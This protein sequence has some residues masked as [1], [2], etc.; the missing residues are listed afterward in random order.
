MP[1]QVFWEDDAQT[2]VRYNFEGTWTWDELYPAYYQAI[3]MEKSVT[4]RVDV[5]LDMRDSG[6]VPANALLHIKNISEKQPPNIGLSIFVTTNAFVTSMYNMAIRVYSKVAYY[7]RITKT[8]EEALAMI[9]A[10]R[11]PVPQKPLSENKTS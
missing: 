11:Q 3:A 2:I 8:P 9:A 5:I 7:F 4:D 6:R 1:I 10:D